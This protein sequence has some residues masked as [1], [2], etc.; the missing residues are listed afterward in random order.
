MRYN[1]ILEPDEDGMWTAEIPALGI[2]TEG[3]GEARAREAAARAVE[4]Y[5]TGA[6]RH[7]LRIPESDVTVTFTL[8]STRGVVGKARSLLSGTRGKSVARKKASSNVATATR[9]KSVVK[10]SAKKAAS[11]KK[12]A[13][14]RR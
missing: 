2:V 6:Q 11:R 12:T 1:V 9:R 13:D 5:I 10:G 7:G 14:K 3:R 8:D 4:G